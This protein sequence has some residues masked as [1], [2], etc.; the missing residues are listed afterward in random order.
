M[1]QLH[2]PLAFISEDDIKRVALN[3][4]KTH[5]RHR[6]RKLD[7]VTTAQLDMV[8]P[9]GIVADGHL[10]FHD[11]D[12]STFTATFEATSRDSNFECKYQLNTARM[13]W[14]SLL[15]SGIV[16][17][18]LFF[19]LQYY[20]YF[21]LRI[22]KEM[23]IVAAGIWLGILL[24]MLAYRLF[25]KEGFRYRKI[26]SIE[27]FKKYIVNEQWVALGGDALDETEEKYL[28]ELRRQCVYNGIGF[29][30]VHSDEEVQLFI[31]PARE[32]AI[33]RKG[34]ILTF[35]PQTNFLD[36][37]I[38]KGRLSWLEKWKLP[39]NRKINTSEKFY[40]HKIILG[41]LFLLVGLTFYG[42]F[43]ESDYDYLTRNERERLVDVVDYEKNPDDL[44]PNFE[45][46]FHEMDSM[47][48]IQR[49]L[50]FRKKDIRRTLDSIA[51][52]KEEKQPDPVEEPEEEPESE[53][54]EQEPE[55][56]PEEIPEPEPESQSKY[57]PK[58]TP[59]K[60]N[61]SSKDCESYPSLTGT[62][63]IVQENAFSSATNAKKRVAAL[64]KKGIKAAYLWQ[65][66]Y[67][68]G[69]KL[70]CV[71]IGGVFGNRSS[72]ERQAK[73]Y[74]SIARKKGITIQKVF[75]TELNPI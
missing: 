6:P 20:N 19:Y 60:K 43:T 69:N 5:Y 48:I 73:S 3:Y 24:L 29:L 51:K 26:F 63:Y 34:S 68:N 41:L 54:E 38:K 1:N 8:T 67:L 46:T 59:K 75:V 64:R 18:I 58:Y 37:Q 9:D 44:D 39:T 40:P 25:F 31:S 52:S 14:D 49:D 45:G 30:M 61:T 70:F 10:W 4:L 55:P 66:C 72:A 36:E 11:A 47:D 16:I 42:K 22:P 27:Q 17:T 13:F 2:F 7:S 33:K 23:G 62:G 56:E 12:G 65:G 53:P 28:E 32:D 71:Y 74:K 21:N 57:Q 15:F 35:L 50:E